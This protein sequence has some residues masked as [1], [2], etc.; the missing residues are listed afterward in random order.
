MNR[1]GSLRLGAA[2]AVGLALAFVAWV[3]VGRDDGGL[4]PAATTA[5]ETT[6]G[7]EVLVAATAAN[8]R[9][10]A[11][12][13]QR[14][15]YWAGPKAG[16]TYELTQTRDGRTYIRYLPRGVALGDRGGAYL[17]VATYPIPDAYTAVQR[18]GAEPGA[19]TFR[20]PKGG[21]AVYNRDAETNVYFAYPRSRYQVEVFDPDPR[22]A[23]RLVASGAVRPIR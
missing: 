9:A 21:L 10:L 18:A 20:I 16:V 17:L 8:L 15:I 6:R 23:R 3:V 7:R 22:T 11:R 14:P 4:T 2:I 13:T 5:S 19:V 12:V 1:A